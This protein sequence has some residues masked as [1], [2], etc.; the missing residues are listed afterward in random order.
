MERD[1]RRF[2]ASDSGNEI[3][4][5]PLDRSGHRILPNLNYSYEQ[6]SITNISLICYHVKV[7]ILEALP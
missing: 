1:S 2:K 7:K 3:N 4:A 6:T 5:A